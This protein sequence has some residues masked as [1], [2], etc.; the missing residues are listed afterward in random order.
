MTSNLKNIFPNAWLKNTFFFSWHVQ[1]C[2]SF[3][4]SLNIAPIPF[5][6]QGHTYWKCGLD[7][8]LMENIF[9]VWFIK[10]TWK[11][12]CTCHTNLIIGETDSLS[13]KSEAALGTKYLRLWSWKKG[14]SHWQLSSYLC[15][16]PTTDFS[17]HLLVDSTKSHHASWWFDLWMTQQ[18]IFNV[19]VIK[20]NEMHSFSNFDKVP[21]MFRTDLPSIIRSLNTVYNATD[22]QHN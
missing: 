2:Q 4:A 11:Y 1:S 8:A 21:H 19:L 6:W 13:P 15:V 17:C 12:S 10:R 14:P 20:T 7:F 5:L 16:N 18:P 9:Y 3:N 22:S